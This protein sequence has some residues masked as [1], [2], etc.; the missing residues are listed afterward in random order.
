MRRPISLVFTAVMALVLLTG[1]SLATGSPASAATIIA[2]TTT[3][4]NGVDDTP[5]LGLICNTTV[6]NT[7]TASG[8]S[9]TVTVEECHGAAGDPRAACGTTTLVLGSRVTHVTQCNAAINGG[10]GTLRCSVKITNNFIDISPNRTAISVNQ[11]VGS[12]GGLTS[13]CDPFPATTLGATVTQCNGSA[14]GGTL[15]G[16]TCT[17]TGMQPLRD[18]VIVNQCNGSANGGGSLVICSTNMVNRI[19]VSATPTPT[20]TRAPTPT[21]TPTRAPTPTPTP[22][23]T[24]TP[25][26]ATPTPVRVTPTPVAPTPTAVVPTPT[27]VAPT[28]TPIQ[29]RPRATPTPIRPVG[30]TPT[31]PTQLPPTNAVSGPPSSDGNSPLIPLGLMVLVGLALFGWFKRQNASFKA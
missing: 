6:V 14:N 27:N 5:G 18:N 10:G 8:T 24:P 31:T 11:C 7:I 26:G 17:V 20:P 15:V 21:P 13:G 22:A 29:G 2:P 23:P 25:V 30:A 16:L 19:I 12:G 9:A 4:S 1:V 28:A 3:C